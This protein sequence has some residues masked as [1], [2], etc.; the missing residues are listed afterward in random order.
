MK[1][2]QR[3]GSALIAVSVLGVAM[4]LF[5]V[6]RIHLDQ[7]GQLNRLPNS[8][9][10]SF[11]WP[12][13]VFLHNELQSGRLPVWNP[14]QFAGQPILA[15][16]IA[17]IL[18]PP[19]LVA[20]WLFSP[21]R[22]LDVLSV[23]HFTA[24]AFFTWLLCGRLG[25]GG[26]ARISAAVM[27]GLSAP[28]LWGIY[29]VAFLYTQAWLPAMLWALHGLLTEARPRWS[30]ALAAFV[31]LAFLGGHTQALL[32]MLQFAGLYGAFGLWRVTAAD[33]RLKVVGLVLLAGALSLGF[34][35]PQLLPTALHHAG[36]A[37]R[38]L[39]G[40][41][42]AEASAGY[43]PW[44]RLL[45]SLLGSPFAAATSAPLIWPILGIPLVA[46]GLCNA[47]SRD[48]WFF[49]A[50]TAVFLALF[51][52]GPQSPVFPLYHRLP[53]GDVFRLPTRISFVY[54]LVIALLLAM[55]V[56]S[57]QALLERR[58]R[59]R[60]A[61]LL[62]LAAASAVCADVYLRTDQ[63]YYHPSILESA[64]AEKWTGRSAF[65][66]LSDATPSRVK[67]G[68]TFLENEVSFLAQP[69]AGMLHG[70][71][72][73]P[74]YDPAIPDAYR[75]YFRPRMPLW[76]GMLRLLRSDTERDDR[77][78]KRLL[79]LMSVHRYTAIA[80]DASGIERF[81]SLRGFAGGPVQSL[82]K[83]AIVVESDSALPRSYTVSCVRPMPDRD[84]AIELLLA[85]DFDPM[86]Q[87]SVTNPEP[88]SPALAPLVAACTERSREP[89]RAAPI[90]EYTTDVVLVD[91]VCTAPC[92]LVL[93]DLRYPGWRVEV[94]GQE[95]LLFA[96]NG[97]FRGV[98]LGAGRH[99]VRYFFAPMSLRIGIG[100]LGLASG[101]ALWVIYCEV[102]SATP[103]RRLAASRTRFD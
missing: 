80:Q 33:E 45:W 91:A 21:A 93:T 100:L 88:G 8:D 38:G 27:Y 18:Y 39:D 94:D 24:A 60:L 90:R 46:I 92:L 34:A 78:L 3:H 58:G 31:S 96:A 72:V 10:L 30:V 56:D 65:S 89:L 85:D 51:M 67:Y 79:D 14:Y 87:A 75:A 25:L 57:C 62:A 71:F 4:T 95:Q 84:A 103:S 9:L 76:H 86:S 55:G 59:S 37:V 6:H 48:Q 50:A 13:L 64:A 20:L 70:I 97:I 49:F 32:Y 28:M 43:V 40:L 2:A 17:G 101:M 35:A 77:Q 66:Y 99:H 36:E 54:L 69:K 47:R 26:A 53:L 7:P 19:N 22:A 61:R 52:I 23:F 73:V 44:N 74:D 5:W 98:V 68:R 102:R 63:V 81:R 82:S 41:S 11:T 1:I 12:N 29:L 16:H 15:N 83:R 42:L